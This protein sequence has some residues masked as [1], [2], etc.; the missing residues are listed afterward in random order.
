MFLIFT[1][2]PTKLSRAE[3]YGERRVSARRLGGVDDYLSN[4]PKQLMSIDRRVTNATS[5]PVDTTARSSEPS[6]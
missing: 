5:G 3:K 4:H 6:P 2:T 1:L